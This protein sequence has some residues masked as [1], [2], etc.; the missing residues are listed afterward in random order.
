[1]ASTYPM[2]NVFALP[3]VQGIDIMA[4]FASLAALYDQVDAVMEQTTVDLDLPCH[5]GCSACC[6]ESVFL[7]P[8]EFYF[9]WQ[10]AQ[11]ELTDEERDQIINKALAL[12]D[13]HREVIEAFNE[14]PPEG[15][16]DHFL[17]AQELRFD[18]PLLDGEGACRIYPVREL[19]SRLFGG[20]FDDKGGIYGCQ[21]V[22]NHLEGRHV[23]LLTARTTAQHL[24]TL[25]LTDQRQVYPFYFHRLYSDNPRELL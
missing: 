24:H 15:E 7:T 6:R 9:A 11:G 2:F 10:W 1:M 14:P 21:W 5:R 3:E 25:P 20:T 4:A 12:Y 16:A 22:K 19:L 13:I 17:M 23:T 8:L 18:C